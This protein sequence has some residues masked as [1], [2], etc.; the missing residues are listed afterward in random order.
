MLRPASARWFELLTACDD[1]ALAVETLAKTGAVELETYSET[2]TRQTLPDLHDGLDRFHKLSQRYQDYWP[3]ASI[4]PSAIT[5]QM[6]RLLE[7]ALAALAAWQAEADPVIARLEALQTE[8]ADLE[9]L[10]NLLEEL[11]DS[12]V[13]LSLLG[14]AGP[15]LAACL[16]MLPPGTR[17]ER[18]SPGVI[19]R[20]ISVAEHRFMLA[21]GPAD[22]VAQMCNELASVK[23]R[24]LPLPDWIKPDAREALVS[25]KTR[26]AGIRQ[27]RSTLA[28]RLKAINNQQHIDE[29]LGA[30]SRLEWVIGHIGR[31]PV[32]EEFAWVTGWTSLTGEGRLELALRRAGVRGMVRYPPA[33]PGGRAPTILSNPWWARPFELFAALLGTPARE[34][35]DPSRLLALIVPTL[36]G[37]M[38]GDVGHGAVLLAAG[39]AYRKRWPMVG[40]LI[41]CGAMSMVFGVL[42]GSVFGRENIIAPLWLAPLDAPV[43]ILAVPLAMGVALLLLGLILNGVEAWWRGELG[44]WWRFDAAVL[45]LYLGLITSFFHQVGQAMVLAGLLWYVTGSLW[46]S[47]GAPQRLGQYLGRLLESVIQLFVNTLSFARVGAFA[48]AHAGLC[49]AAC[50]LARSTEHPAATVLIMVIGNVIIIG[51]EGLVVS[52]QTTRLILFEF[53]I[54]FLRGDGRVFRPLTLPGEEHD[55]D[56][57]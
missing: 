14:R 30:V 32:T 22:E 16:L 34:E 23:A 48:L 39:I 55:G 7:K 40:V 36:F 38:F 19:T 25:V 10:R 6:S 45:L 51:L 37:Y 17:V 42:F 46:Q 20:Q 57:E 56:R 52:V 35:V 15:V 33:P 49:S 21:L 1:L 27:D 44:T 29:I 5:G 41:P 3:A 54:R 9:T 43:V 8:E 24:P 31:L 47:R 4:Q 28:E 13:D 53:F 26:L 18:L 50:A 11:H 2:T 12:A